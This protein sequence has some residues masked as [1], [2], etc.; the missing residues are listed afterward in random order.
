MKRILF[1]TDISTST[2]TPDDIINYK[3]SH[4]NLFWGSI[5]KRVMADSQ[6]WHTDTH[7]PL[8]CSAQI[9]DYRKLLA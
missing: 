1:H 7:T 9:A 6:D 5:R 8:L 4:I 2:E 3:L